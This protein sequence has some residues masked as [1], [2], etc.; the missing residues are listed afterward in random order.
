MTDLSRDHVLSIEQSFVD[1]RIV[2]RCS[3]GE[4]ERTVRRF[5]DRDPA[6]VA[7]QAWDRHAAEVIEVR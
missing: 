6:A 5:K 3:C 1:D 7:A 4:W 2:A